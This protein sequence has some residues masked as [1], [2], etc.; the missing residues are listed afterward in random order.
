MEKPPQPPKMVKVFTY[1]PKPYKDAMFDLVEKGLYC[2][3]GEV[4]REAIRKLL[5]QYGYLKAEPPLHALEER[6]K[7]IENRRPRNIAESCKRIH[8]ICEEMPWICLSV[9]LMRLYARYYTLKTC[10]DT[11]QYVY[12]YRRDFI[13][14]MSKDIAATVLKIP[15]MTRI[16]V[17]P[18][19]FLKRIGENP[20]RGYHTLIAIAMRQIPHT[21]IETS[22]GVKILYECSELYKYACDSGLAT[23][24]YAI[25]AAKK[26]VK[27][28]QEAYEQFKHCMPP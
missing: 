14:T 18:G 28:A 1:V 9:R 12:G 26:D 15:C 17:K 4:M 11:T 21:E 16:V 25:H 10:I 19:Y 7:I 3:V 22:K 27:G 8:A 20:R 2:N 24:K 5:W 23:V 13:L 6:Q